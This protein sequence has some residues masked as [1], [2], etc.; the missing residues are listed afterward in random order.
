MKRLFH[1]SKLVFGVFQRHFGSQKFQKLENFVQKVL[2]IFK[3][4]CDIFFSFF[5][6]NYFLAYFTKTAKHA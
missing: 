1:P 3:N 6:E 2:K 5:Y 4:I